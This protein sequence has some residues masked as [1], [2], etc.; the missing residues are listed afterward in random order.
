MFKEVSERTAHYFSPFFRL[1]LQVLQCLEIGTFKS[2]HD[3]EFFNVHLLCMRDCVRLS[4]QLVLSSKSCCRL[5]ANYEI[6]NKSRPPT[7]I[8]CGG[9]V[10]TRPKWTKLPLR[11]FDFTPL[12]WRPVNLQFLLN[13]FFY[14]FQFLKWF[15]FFFKWRLVSSTQELILLTLLIIRPVSSDQ[16]VFIR[17]SNKMSE[18]N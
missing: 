2:D 14:F 11:I 17:D 8:L 13:F 5:Q 9:G 12:N 1:T 4:R 3:N 7:T 15:T 18:R 16:T 6:F 10:L